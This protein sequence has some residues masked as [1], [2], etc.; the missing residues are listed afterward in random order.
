MFG[1]V[2]EALRR[3]RTDRARE[4]AVAPFI[5]MHDRTLEAIASALPRSLADLR[6]VP[7]IG[8]AKLSSDGDAILSVVTS[9][10]AGT[11]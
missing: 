6:D 1:K 8:P 10:V 11:A 2:F 4:R 3:W 9:I 5:V 7:G